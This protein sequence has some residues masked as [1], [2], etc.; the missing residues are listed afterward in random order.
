MLVCFDG[1]AAAVP[2]RDAGR[3]AVVVWAMCLGMIACAGCGVG[4][5]AVGGPCW[6]LRSRLPP[7]SW[8][9][10][11]VALLLGPS[12]PGGGGY[13]PGRGPPACPPGVCAQALVE[14][15]VQQWQC[16]PNISCWRNAT[17]SVMP[18]CTQCLATHAANPSVCVLGEG[19]PYQLAG[20]LGLCRDAGGCSSGGSSAAHASGRGGWGCGA[21]S[22][23]AR[24]VPP[25]WAA[26][27]VMVWPD[28]SP[29]SRCFRGIVW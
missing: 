8:P 11:D 9:V 1:M 23:Q 7:P 25:C 26:G 15:A 24:R 10:V 5:A 3:A 22:G 21:P 19:V 6:H 20:M 27:V 18:L 29:I 16:G 13:R 28:F 17:A 4:P 12:W 14:L 2:W